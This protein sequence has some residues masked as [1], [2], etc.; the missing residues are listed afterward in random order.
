MTALDDLCTIAFHDAPAGL[1]ARILSHLADTEL[2]LALRS[3]P[4]ADQADILIF[5]LGGGQAAL[6][7]DSEDRLS[8]F[9]CEAVPFA[10]MPGRVLAAML[11]REGLSLLVNP[12][13]PSEMLLEA[14]GLEWLG[15]AL[16]SA[17]ANAETSKMGQGDARLVAPQPEAVA[18]LVEPLSLR[19]GDLAGLASSAALL[20]ADWPDGRHGHV[21]FLGGTEAAHRDAL[22]KSMAEFIAFLPELDGGLDIA[23]SEGA[24]PAGGVM[25]DIPV[26]AAPEPAARRDPNAPPRLR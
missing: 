22:A 13:Q 8:G 12:G 16:D 4:V 17:Q 15:R 18:A 26:P 9:M 25:I 23:F 19:L 1:R 7:C 3:E 24:L 11:A 21:L 10:A 6:A 20:G 14:E 2:F 5:D